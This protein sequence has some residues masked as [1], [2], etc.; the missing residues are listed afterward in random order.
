MDN[1]RP[2]V[3]GLLGSVS[4]VA[5]LGFIAYIFRS[6]I[7]ERLKSS[8][9]H[10]YDLRVLELENQKETRLKSEIVAE[11]LAAWIK[12]G[13]GVDY[14]QLNKLSFQAFVWLPKELA[15]ELSN[16]LAHV[17]GSSDIRSLII[18]VRTHLQGEDDGLKAKDVIVFRESEKHTSINTSQVT[19]DVMAIPKP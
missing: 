8:I 7:I 13:G 4:T 2:F 16:S 18:K 14:H 9:K 5:I 3:M 11:L 10:E 12:E 1:L 15:E 6:W 19:S 17:P